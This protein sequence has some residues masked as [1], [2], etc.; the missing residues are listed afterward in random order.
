MDARASLLPSRKGLFSLAVTVQAVEHVLARADRYLD[1]YEASFKDD[2]GKIFAARL[3][4]S[5]A[6]AAAATTAT[7]RPSRRRERSE[8]SQQTDLASLVAEQRTDGEA[9]R[10]AA[11]EHIALGS[12]QSKASRQRTKRGKPDESRRHQSASWSEFWL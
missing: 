7:S 12:R 1:Y 11:A 9:A 5:L 8:T 10:T 4:L 2:Y 6:I 3:V